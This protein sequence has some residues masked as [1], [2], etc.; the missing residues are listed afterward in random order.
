[1][2]AQQTIGHSQDGFLKLDWSCKGLGV[3]PIDCLVGLET[4]HNLLIDFLWAHG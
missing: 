3:A 4:A 2:I 1:V